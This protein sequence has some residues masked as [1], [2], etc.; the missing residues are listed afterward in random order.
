VK[1]L[2]QYN[3]TINNILIYKIPRQRFSLEVFGDILFQTAGRLG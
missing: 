1:A 3:Y 2:S